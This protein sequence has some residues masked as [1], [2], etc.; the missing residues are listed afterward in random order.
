MQWGTDIDY[1][2]NNSLPVGYQNQSTA[3]VIGG[4]QVTVDGHGYGTLNGNG[5]VWYTFA[6]G[7]SNYPRRPHAM[8]VANTTDSVFQ[9]LRFIRSQMWYVGVCASINTVFCLLRDSFQP[10][11]S[12]KTHIG[13]YKIELTYARSLSIIW[14]ERTEFNSIYVNNTSSQGEATGENPRTLLLTSLTDHTWE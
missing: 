9:G 5:D 13:H 8:T 11:N 1:W 12:T 6:S 2:L 7:I 4:D 10:W 3:W 14:T